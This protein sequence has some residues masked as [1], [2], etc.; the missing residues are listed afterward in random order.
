V[1]I[2]LITGLLATGA[3]AAF[4]YKTTLLDIGGSITAAVVCAGVV[5]LLITGAI[6]GSRL[7]D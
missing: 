4:L 6:Y 7:F 3:F 1:I 2:L 5:A